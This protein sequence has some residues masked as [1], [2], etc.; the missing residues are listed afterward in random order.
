MTTPE[1]DAPSDNTT[2]TEV[3]DRYRDA[4]FTADFSAEEGCS[5]RC[6]ACGS[7]VDA[8]R[9]SAHSIRRLEGASDPSDMLALVA[10]TCPVCAAQ[11]TA[12]LG[13]GP[14]ASA[15]DADVL[16]A[17]RDRRD[18]DV[19]PPNSAPDDGAH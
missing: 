7:V 18:D 19:L 11:G 9:V 1:H 3:I 17:L 15:V 8:G 13:Y 4:G 2:L 16:T 10:V 12:V 6:G 5:L 14:M